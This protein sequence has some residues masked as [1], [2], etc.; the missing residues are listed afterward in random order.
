[1]NNYQPVGENRPPQFNAPQNANAQPGGCAPNA[2]NPAPPQPPGN[3]QPANGAQAPGVYPPPPPGARIPHPP[4]AMAQAAG[5]SSQGGAHG[6]SAAPGRSRATGPYPPPPGAPI[7]QPAGGPPLQSAYVPVYPV[8]EAQPFN[9]TRADAWFAIACFVLGFLFIRWVTLLFAPV[10]AGGLGVSLFTGVYAGTV[11]VYARVRHIRPAAASWF[12]LVILLAV[13]ATYGLWP[14]G[15]MFFLRALLLFGAAV[16]WCGSLFGGLMAHKSSNYFFFDVINLLFVVPLRNFGLIFKGLASFKQGEKRKTSE[17]SGKTRL[18]WVYALLGLLLCIPLLFLLL[19]MLIQADGGV[20]GQMLGGV[21]RWAA[22]LQILPE[23]WDGLW[24][25]V[26]GFPVALY[27]FGLIAGLSHKRYTNG[28]DKKGVARGMLA[29]RVIPGATVATVLGVVCA[30][31]VV[32]IACQVPY[33]FSAF[34]GQRPPGYEVYSQ[35]ARDGFFELCRIAVINL[36]LLALACAV[37][38]KKRQD[39]T[40]LRWLSIALSALTLLLIATAFSKMA[41][42]IGA[43]GLTAR[44]VMVCVFLVFLA[45]VCGAVILLQFKA[46]SIVRFALVAGAA[47]V[48]LLCL[49]NPDG[50]VARYNA[51]RYLDGSLPGFDTTL[52]ASATYRGGAEA[53]EAGRLVM[54]NTTDSALRSELYQILFSEQRTARETAGTIN[55]TL[56]NQ[57]IRAMEVSSAEYRYNRYKK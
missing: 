10:I 2:Q 18:T 3:H 14:G 8:K 33:F 20:F 51:G 5:G 27:L 7:P 30:L 15:S 4:N 37:C 52:V 54:E 46:F 23:L 22:S 21:A 29:L 12:W 44:R 41:L 31:Y 34:A 1:M 36:G 11:L 13:G 28:I 19:P 49:T 38:Q 6:S 35:L 26:L 48:C 17:N 25:L 53:F 16:Y 42:Y 40:P 9:G 57:R 32:F 43:Y 50:A 24:Q 47:L 55:D 45:L 56:A 39:F